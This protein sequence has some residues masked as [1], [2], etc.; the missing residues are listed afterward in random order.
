M[1]AA[2]LALGFSLATFVV[3]WP[4]ALVTSLIASTILA[5]VTLMRGWRSGLL[6]LCW[7]I[8]PPLAFSFWGHYGV[9]LNI[10]I[11]HSGFVWLLAL[12]LRR[13]SNWRQVLWITL[14]VGIAFVLLMYA[15]K[16]DFNQ[17]WAAQ[18]N[19]LIAQ[20]ASSNPAESMNL[21]KISRSIAFF[22]PIAVGLT[23]ASNL[24]VNIIALILARC[25]QASMV[26]PGGF[27]REFHSIRLSYFAAMVW[28]LVAIGSLLKLNILLNMLPVVI[29]VFAV[30]GIALIHCF[31]S[32]QPKTARIWLILM[33]LVTFF[34]LPY[35]LLLLAL[36]GLIDSFFNLRRF[37]LAKKT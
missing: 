32:T 37:G 3:G 21:E 26:N 27:K 15:V 35:S 30:A 10:A 7:S 34:V 6:V 17:W 13:Y 9:L 19:K 25:W 8:L 2:W 12:A 20:V 22:S 28:V 1:L 5:L 16:P 33:Y 29:L 14:T 11:F 18:F 36:V 31:A 24:L 4:L 23:I